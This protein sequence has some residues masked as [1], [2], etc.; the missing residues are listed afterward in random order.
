MRYTTIIF[1]LF[2]IGSCGQGTLADQRETERLKIDKRILSDHDRIIVLAKV[3]GQS[4][5][6]NVTGKDFPKETETAYNVLKN[7]S[8]QIIYIGEFP[9]SE[10]GDWTLGLR[11]YFGD[12]GHLIAFVK[13]L[14]YFNEECTNKGVVERIAELYDN[15]FRIIQTTK[16]LMDY[17]GRELDSIKCGHTYKWDFDKK[18]SV[19]EFVQLKKIRL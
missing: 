13:V 14:T 18:A 12:N 11:H 5:L 6:I 17:K 2:S 7:Q 8:G 1:L 4:E 16:S 10:S 19:D 9:T 3:K 15:D